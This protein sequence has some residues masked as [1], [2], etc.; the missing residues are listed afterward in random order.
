MG[1]S[2]IEP[3]V[4]GAQAEG[5]PP[6]ET[7][8]TW[9]VLVT[10]DDLPFDVQAITEAVF[11]GAGFLGISETTEGMARELPSLP[12]H[13]GAHAYYRESGR[14][15]STHIDW[16]TVTWRS[17]TIL[18]I[19]GAAL[20]GAL[21]M[22][23]NAT[24]R[25]FRHRVLEVPVDDASHLSVARLIEIRREVRAAGYR[26]PWRRTSLDAARVSELE[27]MINQR[28]E[29]CRE[30]LKRGLLAALRV[31]RPPTDLDDKGRLEQYDSLE[32]QIWICLEDGELDAPRHKLVLDL[33]REQRLEVQ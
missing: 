2:Q 17:L 21:T 27:G 18:V 5:E 13:A 22:S 12:L 9:A 1:L 28:I 33:I 19:L 23:R 10:R 30:S 24:E 32:R 29:E 16:L 4:Y 8:A 14:I 26:P 6:V 20:R 11:E 7:V 15:P 25:W 3:G 31:L